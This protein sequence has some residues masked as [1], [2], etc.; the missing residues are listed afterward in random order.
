MNT[1]Q[2]IESILFFKGQPV[3]YKE[4]ALLL[5]ISPEEVQKTVEE[6]S[7][8]YEERGVSI[9]YNTHECELV[10]PQAQTELILKLQKQEIESDLSNASLETLSIILYMGPITRS[11]ID[12]IRGVNSQFTL[13]GLLVRGLIEKDPQS[14]TPLYMVT[15]DTIKFLGLNKLDELPNFKEIRQE[16]AQFIKDNSNNATQ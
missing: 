1:K 4:L 10:T 14:K 8:E 5:E 6:L 13:R 9:V 16:L 12:F 3:S 15:L 7:T 2:S 11:M